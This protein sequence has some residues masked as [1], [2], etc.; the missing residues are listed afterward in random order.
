MLITNF[1]IVIFPFLLQNGSVFGLP[2]TGAT[3][4]SGVSARAANT[5]GG[6][7]SVTA[8]M[9]SAS[10]TAYTCISSTSGAR[11]N[12]IDGSVTNV[13][14]LQAQL[15]NYVIQ[16]PTF[17]FSISLALFGTSYSGPL[18]PQQ[19]D[20]SVLSNIS[21]RQILYYFKILSMRFRLMEICSYNNA[22][23]FAGAS[24]L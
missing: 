22:Q 2:F 11:N 7:V 14:V 20:G 9:F 1:S 12:F 5:I 3:S 6:N 21:D 19:V 13:A 18:V 8:A 4:V 17:P 15:L 10:N 16:Q 23:S 24:H